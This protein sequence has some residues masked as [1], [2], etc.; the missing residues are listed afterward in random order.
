MTL[1]QQKSFRNVGQQKVPEMSESQQTLSEMTPSQQ[2]VAEMT[3]SHQT[4]SGSFPFLIN[5][6]SGLK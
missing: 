4:G 2:T 1:S 6:L 3:A 5:V